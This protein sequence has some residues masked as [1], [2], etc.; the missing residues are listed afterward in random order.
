MKP[1]RIHPLLA[2]LA[3]LV[4]GVGARAAT[5]PPA[6]PD[7]TGM[8]AM[9]SQMQDAMKSMRE[10][11]PGSKLA[12]LEYRKG[13]TWVTMATTPAQ[14]SSGMG[15][16]TV[17]KMMVGLGGPKETLMMPGSA[18]DVVLEDPQPRFRFTGEKGD[19]MTLQIGVFAVNGEQRVTTVDPAKQVHFFKK[20]V[21][22]K[23]EKVGDQLWELTPSHSLDPGQYGI[24]NSIMG[25]IA[26]FAIASH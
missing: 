2:A 15:A 7:T 18:S 16:T 22:L 10:S 19:A 13:D 11:M 20:A 4:V 6:P 26:D 17:V 8:S 23:V 25:P 21:D 9:T 14:V 12:K 3:L 1:R 5:A 24:A